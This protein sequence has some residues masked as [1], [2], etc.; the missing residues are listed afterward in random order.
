MSER[1]DK[2]LSLLDGFLL[3]D[4]PQGMTSHDVVDL[5]RK[6]F[7]IKKVG[8]TGT[9]DP[10][11][12]GLLILLLGRYTSK[13]QEFLLLDKV[14]EGT[15]RLGITTDTWDMEGKIIKKVEDFKINLPLV[16]SAIELLDGSIL[17]TVPPYS[18]VKYKGQ[19]LYKL[20]RRNKTVPQIKK[21]VRV[22]WL[23]WE[24]K[25]GLVNFKIRC[26][27]GTYVRSIAYELG[28][29]LGCGATLASLRRLAIGPW[30]VEDA[31]S[32]DDF[33]KMSYENAAQ[34]IKK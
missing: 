14:Y 11:A 6:K 20:A 17:Q 22:K 9:L 16:K 25:D 29:I 4:K 2:D 5:V 3:F 34:L 21:T 24:Y 26:S 8:H 32:V 31:V 18:A 27:K 23:S 13:Q 19:T 1:K 10:L 15:I 30:E 12:T 33:I 28:Q 7:N